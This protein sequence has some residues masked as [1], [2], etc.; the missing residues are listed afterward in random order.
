MIIL[1]SARSAVPGYSV[2]TLRPR[3]GSQHVENSTSGLQKSLVPKNKNNENE[4]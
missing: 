1:L 3:N 4:K 2:A